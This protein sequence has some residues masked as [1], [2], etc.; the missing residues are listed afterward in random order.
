M[1]V[2]HKDPH[3]FGLE[4]SRWTLQAIR[5]VCD[6]LSIADASGMSHLLK[7]I[8]IS[9]KRGREHIHSPDPDYDAKLADLERLLKDVRESRGLIVLLYLDEL[10]YYRQPS[11][12]NC[13][14]QCGKT[15]PLAELSHKSNATTRVAGALDPLYGRIIYRQAPR[16]GVRELIRL[17]CDIRDAYS[18]AQR[19]YLVQDNW[20]VH[21][22]PDVLVALEPQEFRWPTHPAPNWPT[23]PSPSAVRRFGNLRLPIQMVLLPT[24]A[25]WTNPIEKLWR[26]LK[27]VVLHMHRL[28]DDLPELR[29]R[30]CWFLDQFASGSQELLRYVG[31]TLPY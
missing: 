22:H 1:E 3:C 18:N 10:T 23:E 27:Q 16:V 7:R 8:G 21:F 5:S 29:Q 4:L 19:I 26:M 11:V 25:P 9:W 15:Q 30:V 2:V 31:I 20:S 13:Y 17:Y 28:S 24:Y 12:A 6:W 14:E